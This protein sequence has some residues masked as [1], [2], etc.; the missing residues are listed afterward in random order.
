M[1]KIGILYICTGDY[2]LF[3]N[4][5]YESFEKNF[6]KNSEIHYFVFSDREIDF[7]GKSNIHF[8]K[9][10]HQPWPLIT[11]LRYH[12]FCE[13]ENELKQCDFLFFW[14]S[15][16]KCVSN[17][18][19]NEI[20]P[21]M[22]EKLVF[23]RHAGYLKSKKYQLPYD[24]NKKSKAYIP[25]NCGGSYIY[26]GGNGGV[27][28][29]FLKMCHVLKDNIDY[30]LKNNYI[31]KFHDESHINHYKLL[32]TDYKLLHTGYLYPVGFEVPFEKKIIGV[33]KETKFDIN[34][35]RIAEQRKRS[36][37]QKIFER[38]DRRLFPFFK[39]IRDSIFFKKIKY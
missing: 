12:T 24:R 13:Y 22:D 10:Q 33:S 34:K 18:S 23:I 37:K 4:D 14:N 25:Y 16:L 20:L 32:I 11:L 35:F 6:C 5:F 30:D 26:G 9:I 3:W 39:F 27:T 31:A 1:K 17:I 28:E 21:T 2:V 8:H 38:L 7:T 19:E 29:Y 36:F 15:N